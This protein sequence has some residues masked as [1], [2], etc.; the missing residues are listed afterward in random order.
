MKMPLE[1]IGVNI[2]VNMISQTACPDRHDVMCCLPPSYLGSAY[3]SGVWTVT[4]WP[5]GNPL[6]CDCRATELKQVLYNVCMKCIIHRKLEMGT[7]PLKHSTN[8]TFIKDIEGF[9]WRLGIFAF[10]HP[11][12]RVSLQQLRKAP[13]K[14]AILWAQL[15]IGAGISWPGK[16]H[17]ISVQLLN[18]VFFSNPR[19]VNSSTVSAQSI[20]STRRWWST[21][22]RGI[23]HQHLLRFV[24][25][26]FPF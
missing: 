20:G 8:K 11:I 16:F 24:A 4:K 26:Y 6:T 13:K 9:V 15:S 21:A 7:A 5:P 23:L 1:T 3:V 22:Q 17:T 19:I 2:T 25:L 10:Q 12:Q 18:F 14:H